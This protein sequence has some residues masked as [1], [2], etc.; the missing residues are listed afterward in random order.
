[1]RELNM[2][3]LAFAALIGLF[4]GLF[5]AV[6]GVGPIIAQESKD[7]AEDQSIYRQLEVFG[8][9]FEKVTS[10]Y[11]DDV[12]AP[13]LVEAAIDGMLSSLD[14]HSGY[15][16]ADDFRKFQEQTRGEFGG[17][18]ITVT[19]E[20]G[21]VKVISPLDGT[22]ADKVGIKS[23]DFITHADGEALLGLTLDKAVEKLRGPVGSEIQLT[24]SRSG[25]PEPLEFIL[26]RDAINIPA[27][28]ARVESNVGVFRVATF[29]DHAYSDLVEE[30]EK[31]A[32]ELGGMDKMAGVVLD[33][34]NNPGGLLNQAVL[35]SGAF[36]KHGQLVVSTRGRGSGFRETA[37]RG[38]LAE[39][40]PIVVLINGGSASA[41]E[42][43][44]G[45]LQDHR[46]AV[47]VGTKSF[48]K[49]SVQ[50][51]VPL[52]VNPMSAADVDDLGP[53]AIRITTGRYYTPSGR[54]IQA[55]GIVPD[56]IVEQPL[57]GAG[58]SLALTYEGAAFNSE[59]NLRNR[60]ENEGLGEE[61][62]A[63][64]EEEIRRAEDA[65]AIREDDYQLAYALDLIKGL[66][67]L[68]NINDPLP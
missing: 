23:G 63:K 64:I 45:A 47:V 66:S 1:M 52:K 33:L 24:I 39:G 57:P 30:M 20:E 18:G 44:A 46:R 25:E 26:V 29:S 14:P 68:T 12:D 54:S 5:L 8:D 10:S 51:V 48:G 27:I 16:R 3:R 42:I 38:D 58:G 50:T 56:I 32:E 2:A 65:A 11:V 43:V 9:I 34:R 55:L 67:V 35:I 22:P 15:I 13:E 17:L 31:K 21:W 36:L 4:L 37:Q 6:E 60:L 40:K 61:E 28:R 49:G 7:Q 41:S 19:H 59:D 62:E 53:A